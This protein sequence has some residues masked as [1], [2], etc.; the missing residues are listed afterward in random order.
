MTLVRTGRVRS[1]PRVGHRKPAR[2]SIHLRVK[3]KTGIDSAVKSWARLSSARL[4]FEMDSLETHTIIK[5][6]RTRESHFA[7]SIHELA[8]T[9]VRY[10]EKQTDIGQR[11]KAFERARP[12]GFFYPRRRRTNHHQNV[13]AQS[14]HFIR[15]AKRRWKKHATTSWN[16]F[17]PLTSYMQDLPQRIA[18]LTNFTTYSRLSVRLARACTNGFKYLGGQKLQRGRVLI[19]TL[20]NHRAIDY[21]R[22]KSETLGQK[23]RIDPKGYFLPSGQRAYEQ[24][25]ELETLVNLPTN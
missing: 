2:N 22:L 17:D 8:Q 13:D 21:L 5:K 11:R 1:S 4:H 9:Q 23:L 19:G 10:A 3:T 24:V 6:Y 14:I 18:T 15:L 12:L 16:V 25:D 7:E 20:G